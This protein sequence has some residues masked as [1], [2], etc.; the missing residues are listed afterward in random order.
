MYRSAFAAASLAALTL[1]AP[2]Y[3]GNSEGKFQV[4]AF[5][6]GLMPDGEIASGTTDKIALPAESQTEAS[7]SLVPT[8][9][10]EYFFTP[11]ISVETI[12]CITPHDA[13]ILPATV[14]AKYH[15]QTAPKFR[16]YIGAGP[17]HFFIFNE[18][19]DSTARSLGATGVDL[20]DD[21]G[22]ALQTLHKLDPWAVSAGAAYRF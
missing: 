14:T 10:I 3:A 11:S 2:A 21:W 5:L 12:C 7:S 9:A 20:S 8:I 16:P 1:A 4:R 22:F 19:V 18:D 15:I 6:T 13:P 17:A